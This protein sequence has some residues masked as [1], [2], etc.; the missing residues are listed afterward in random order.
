[1]YLWQRLL[2]LVVV[3]LMMVLCGCVSWH[4]Q[5]LLTLHRSLQLGISC[6]SA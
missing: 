5:V 3:V 6:C 1:M 4:G 2:L